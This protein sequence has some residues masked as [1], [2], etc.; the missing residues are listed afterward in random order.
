[1]EMLHLV[2]VS[3]NFL[4]LALTIISTT[5]EKMLTIRVFSTGSSEKY[6]Y[7]PRGGFLIPKSVGDKP[8]RGSWCNVSPSAFKLRGENYFRHASWLLH[9]SSPLLIFFIFIYLFIYHGNLSDAE[10]KRSILL[11]TIALIYLLVSTYSPV[12]GKYII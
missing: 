3:R 1:M 12:L 2:S 9:A 7:N 10:I 8:S 11:L 4:I 5:L 6:L